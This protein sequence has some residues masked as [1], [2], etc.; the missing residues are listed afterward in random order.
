MVSLIEKSK[1]KEDKL[2]AEMSTINEGKRVFDKRARKRRR[3]G[4]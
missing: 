1:R 4:W 3:R 2:R